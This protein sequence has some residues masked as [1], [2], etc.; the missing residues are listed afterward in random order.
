VLDD[1]FHRL[2]RS[3]LIACSA[4]FISFAPAVN[5]AT[6]LIVH[7]SLASDLV[8]AC[9]YAAALYY[10]TGFAF[11]Y[12][13]AVSFNGEFFRRV[14]GGPYAA[15]IKTFTTDLEIARDEFRASNE[16]EHVRA[17]VEKAVALSTKQLS[18][19]R[20]FFEGSSLR[21]IVRFFLWEGAV[22]ATMFLAVT[23]LAFRNI[24]GAAVVRALRAM[25]GL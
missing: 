7:L 16:P 4:S 5:D 14:E 12:W 18:L 20:G 22:P 9:L 1:Q 23:G 10:S 6:I 25:F 3:A 2:K 24:E 15:L 8:R 13:R 17:E 11:E 19:V 21:T